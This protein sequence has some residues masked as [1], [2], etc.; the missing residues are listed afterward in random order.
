[1]IRKTPCLQIVKSPPP[2]DRILALFEMLHQNLLL[3]KNTVSEHTEWDPAE[4]QDPEWTEA[5][6]KKTK[7][8]KR[9]DLK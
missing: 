1:M 9:E 6:Y 5:L 3:M 7:N 4:G 8:K 2:K